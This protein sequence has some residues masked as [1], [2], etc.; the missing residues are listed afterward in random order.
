MLAIMKGVK[1]MRIL[2]INCNY[3]GTTLHQCMVEHLEKLG[4]DNTIYV[5]TYDSSMAVIKPNSNV[6][7]SECFNKWDRLWFDYKQNKII[8]DIQ[9]KI[10]IGDFDCIHAYTLFTDGNCAHILSKKYNIPY[11][12]AVRSTDVNIFFK[13]MIYLRY[14]G[15][16][17]MKDASRVFFLSESYKTKVMDFYVKK[18]LQ[19]FILN[20]TEVI[21][22]GIDDFWLNN[23]LGQKERNPYDKKIKLIYAGR[24]DKN[25]NITTTQKAV[26]LLR[27][28][29]YNASLTVIGKIGDKRVYKK[30][31]KHK[32]TKVLSAMTKENLINEYRQHDV[33]VMPSLTESFG[34]V[35][36]EAISQG[37]P[38]IYT[39]GQGFDGQFLDGIVGYSV[40]SSDFIR[41]ASS[42]I[43]IIQKYNKFSQNCWRSFHKFN[44]E[45]ICK[46]YKKIYEDVIN[47]KS[48]MVFAVLNLLIDN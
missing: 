35:Y 7:V 44:W 21:P 46:E 30:I 8:E 26:D 28:E 41:I 34:L 14:R 32:Y 12:V 43:K 31:S 9:S 23:F 17:I 16:S 33:L 47:R 24:I 13:Y 19:E 22:N 18:D 29:G 37:L 45:N 10:D 40:N 1:S 3:L 20:K 38:V 48:Y 25:K 36:A 39:K 11:V 27:L 2:H 15:I 42:V 4:V 5:P 6:Y